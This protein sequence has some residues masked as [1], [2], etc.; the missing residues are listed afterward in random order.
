MSERNPIQGVIFDMDGVL[1]D[2]EPFLYFAAREM[3][4]RRYG[5]KVLREDFA[6]FVGTGENRYLGGVAE[7]YGISLQLPDDKSLTYDIYLDL[8]DGE[9]E[10][11]PGV[12]EFV[13]RCQSSGLK[14]AVA[15]SADRIKMEGNLR[16]IKLSPSSFDGL[17]TGSDVE[18]KK[19][20]PEIF[21]TAVRQL[22]L[23]P[24]DCLIIEDSPSGVEAAKGA[25]AL[26]LGILSTF[27]R[28]ELLAKG[29]NWISESLSTVPA[30]L[31]ELLFGESGVDSF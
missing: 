20:H 14:T 7:T 25:G 28:E 22:R 24:T 29:A 19:P 12:L 5:V 15:T 10:A 2:S 6:P 9:L 8:I 13:R 21:L 30:E 31:L 3:F 4:F 17:V 27:S 26:C 1:C 11:L 23:S 18:K 16:Q